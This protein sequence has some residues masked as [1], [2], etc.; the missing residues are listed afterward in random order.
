MISSRAEMISS[1]AEM[2]SNDGYLPFSPPRRP[3]DR[4][5]RDFRAAEV[6]SP[7]PRADLRIV[8]SGVCATTSVPRP[9]RIHFSPRKGVP[10]MPT[11]PQDRVAKLEFY[12]V[13]VPIW[14]AVAATIGL[15]PASVTALSGVTE[16]A[17]AAY[18][19]HLAALDASKAATAAFYDKIRAMHNAP[20]MG[21][22]MIQQIKNK[23]A[24]TND[25]NVYALAQIP[26]PALPA[27]APAPGTPTGFTVG[28]LGDGSLE[29]KWKCANPG[30]RGGVIYHVQR[31]VG[32]AVE[33][34]FAGATGTRTFLDQTL[35][36]GAASPVT[37]QVT[38]VRSTARGNPA[39]FVVNFGTGGSGE[40]VATV[41]PKLAA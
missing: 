35:P 27:P 7:P 29:L 15:V 3:F 19:A 10:P 28:L 34:E 5:F 21:A 23:A 36:A 9:A 31:R 37:Y 12:E 25:P 39:Q 17:R 32:S 8:R 13:H 38:A 33:W 1:R 22:D 4:S 14:Q 41:G 24:T 30:G 20:G 6:K 40:A 2:I 18:T 16:E 26:A 11:V